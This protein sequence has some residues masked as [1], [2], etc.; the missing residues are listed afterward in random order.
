MGV[1]ARGR[2]AAGAW[3]GSCRRSHAARYRRDRRVPSNIRPFTKRQ[4]TATA[5]R[6][7]HAR[8]AQPVGPAQLRP[9]PRRELLGLGGLIARLALQPALDA[10]AVIVQQAVV[11]G[12]T[13]PSM[14]SF[15]VWPSWTKRLAAP[16]EQHGQRGIERGPQRLAVDAVDEGD[17]GRPPSPDRAPGRR[18][19]RAAPAP[20]CSR[21]RGAG[22]SRCVIPV[23]AVAKLHCRAWLSNGRWTTR[24][25]G[26]ARGDRQGVVG[27]AAVDD[28]DLPRPRQALQRAADI[29]GFVVGQ[30][31]GSDVGQHGAVIQKAAMWLL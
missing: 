18:S 9:R 1:A 8:A 10:L 26:E 27:R 19:R 25:V 11:S 29:G 5:T 22:S 13:G 15:S 14:R 6:P 17:L 3:K 31:D 24:D 23:S 28:H 20:P 7:Q 4:W 30:D 16:T 12:T 2:D 21:R